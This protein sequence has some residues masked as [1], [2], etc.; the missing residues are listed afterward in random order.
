LGKFGLCLKPFSETVTACSCKCYYDGL[1][2]DKSNPPNHWHIDHVCQLKEWSSIE[3]EADRA[4]KK[5]KWEEMI[6]ERVDRMVQEYGP[7]DPM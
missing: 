1:I 2:L 3:K 5:R 7:S 4:E 6:N